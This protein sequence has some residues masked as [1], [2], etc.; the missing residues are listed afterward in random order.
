MSIT[1]KRRQYGALPIRL[2]D[3]GR[4]RIMLITSRRSGEWIIPKGWP[5]ARLSGAESAAREAFEEAGLVGLI[6]GDE[7]IG[8][9]EYAKRSAS[10]R[11]MPFEVFVFL[12]RVHEQREKWP[13]KGQRLLRWCDLHEAAGLIVEPGLARLVAHFAGRW[14]ADGAAGL[15][16]VE[17]GR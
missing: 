15:A 2:D 8:V 3:A 12:L 7:P 9:Y 6:I 17:A 11:P 10:R 16:T 14:L 5:V 1:T 4:P 13:E